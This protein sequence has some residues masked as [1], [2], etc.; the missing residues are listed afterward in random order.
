[1][2]SAGEGDVLIQYPFQARCNAASGPLCVIRW[3]TFDG[4]NAVSFMKSYCYPPVIRGCGVCPEE[5][6]R[7]Y[8]KALE[9]GSGPSFR[10]AVNV[11]TEL[12]ALAG[13]GLETKERERDTVRL[14]RQYAERMFHDPSVDINTLCAV[15][16]VHRSTLCRAFQETSFGSPA[17]YLRKL[18]MHH[19]MELLASGRCSVAEAARRSGFWNASYFTQT[20]KRM[21]GLTPKQLK[22]LRCCVSPV[23]NE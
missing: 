10:S 8:E 14:F 2:E 20:A 4:E 23:E 16:N 12:L 21:T 11:I 5:G 19:A 13:S 9:S 17:E 7:Q 22:S 1:M 6:F 3:L 15:L 18:R